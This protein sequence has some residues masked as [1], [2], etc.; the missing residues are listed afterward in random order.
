[1]TNPYRPHE[2]DTNAQ[3]QS[4]S[5]K[6]AQYNTKKIEKAIIATGLTTAVVGGGFVAANAPKPTPGQS[7]VRT[8]PGLLP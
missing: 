4:P 5:V 1:M 7:S 3:E 6:A 2:A 8:C